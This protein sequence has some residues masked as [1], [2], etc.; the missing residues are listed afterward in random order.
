MTQTMPLTITTE[1]QDYITENGLQ[2]PFEQMLDHIP[3]RI[4]LVR[5]IHVFLQPPYDAGEPSVILDVKRDRLTKE[6][7][8]VEWNW[9]RWVLDNFPPEEWTHFCLLTNYG[10][11]PDHERPTIS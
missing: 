2:A 11:G 10:H 9:R 4:P 5:G 3:L 8:G 6:Y 7:D 1:A